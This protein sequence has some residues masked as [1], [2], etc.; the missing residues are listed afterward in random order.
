MKGY[1]FALQASKEFS[2]LVLYGGVQ[3]EK[4]TLTISFTSTDPTATSPNVNVDLEGSNVVRG[5][6]GAGLNLGVVKLFADANFGAI[7]S[8]S[9]GIGFGF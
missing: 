6:I 1:G 4:S 7:T 2:V 8:F 9:G 5:T 3:Y